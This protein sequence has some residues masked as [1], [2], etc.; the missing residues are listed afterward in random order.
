MAFQ[1]TFPNLLLRGERLIIRLEGFTPET[2]NF[3]L[4]I[5]HP[6]MALGKGGPKT[7]LSGKHHRLKT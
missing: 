7:A 6:D 5:P 4:P 1:H 2:L 3:C